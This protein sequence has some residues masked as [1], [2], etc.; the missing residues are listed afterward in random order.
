M[1]YRKK[2]TNTAEYIAPEG[3]N[4]QSAHGGAD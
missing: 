3:E 1:L 4:I 2:N